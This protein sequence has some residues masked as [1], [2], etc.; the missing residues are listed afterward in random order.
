MITMVV[1]KLEI[2]VIPILQRGGKYNESHFQ[3][4]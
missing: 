3:L 1:D 4:E 2:S